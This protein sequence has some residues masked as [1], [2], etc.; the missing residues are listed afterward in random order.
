MTQPRDDRGRYTYKVGVGSVLAAGVIGIAAAVSV[1]AEGAGAGSTA[2][3]VLRGNAPSVSAPAR[4]A[5]GQQRS[6]RIQ[7]QLIRSGLRPSLQAEADSGSCAADAR[8]QVREFLATH[9]CEAV[10]R[11]LVEVHRG[12]VAAVVAVAWIEMVELDDATELKALV[13]RPGTGNVD[14]LSPSEG[15]QVIELAEPAY[16]SRQDG[17]L[18]T[19]VEVQPAT[20]P[21]PRRVLEEIAEEAADG[22]IR[23]D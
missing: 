4:A 18:V 5:R 2:S 17:R 15:T 22:A 14:Q 1:G 6:A 10:Y 9:P 16:A 11:G 23:P 3:T 8:G 13:D 20:A 12:P 21:V 19:T 7:R